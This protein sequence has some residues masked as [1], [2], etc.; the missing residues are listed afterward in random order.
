MQTDNSQAVSLYKR[1]RIFKTQCRF[2]KKHK[3]WPNI[4]HPKTFSEKIQHRKFF[5]N[6]PLYSICADK[7]AVREYV[8]TKVGEQYLVPLIDVV[9]QPEQLNYQQ[10]GD[11]FVIKTTHDSGGVYIYRN[12]QFDKNNVIGRIKKSLLKDTGILRDEPWYSAIKPKIMVESLLQTSSGEL[13]SDYKF[14]MFN[15]GDDIEFF[16]QVDYDRDGDHHRSI[17][18]SAKQLIN[19][20]IKTKS[21][22][23]PL[24]KLDNYD[25]MVWVAKQLAADFDYVRVDLYNFDGKIYF[26]ELTFAHG[27]GFRRFKP[28]HYDKEWGQL[29]KSVN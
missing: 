6:Q 5:G 4:A 25:E 29:W 23:K 14:H 24:A 15:Q 2:L 3:Y 12:G 10:Y 1:W 13:P 21:K 26:G 8:K 28:A 20:S 19:L 27:S 18:D 11:Q 9:E 22:N 17:Y 7:F 16:L